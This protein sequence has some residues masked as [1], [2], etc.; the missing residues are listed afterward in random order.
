MV[1]AP[2]GFEG[3][4]SVRG[5]MISLTLRPGAVL[6]AIVHRTVE[7]IGYVVAGRGQLWRKGDV[8]EDIVYLAPGVSLTVPVGA[9]FSVSQ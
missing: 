3:R 2:G 6:K 1:A 7:E 9:R 5:S 4:A 8:T